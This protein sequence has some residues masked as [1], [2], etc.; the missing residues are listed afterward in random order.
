MQADRLYLV[1]LST[2]QRNSG[3][4][5]GLLKGGRDELGRK[6]GWWAGGGLSVMPAA[7]AGMTGREVVECAIS[8]NTP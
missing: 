5:E 1:G 4:R 7:S 3:L 2:T 6:G 8:V